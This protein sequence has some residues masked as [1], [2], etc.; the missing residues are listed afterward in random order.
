MVEKRQD[1]TVLTERST[2]PLGVIR[3]EQQDINCSSGENAYTFTQMFPTAPPNPGPFRGA[4][5]APGLPISKALLQ[6]MIVVT[7]HSQSA[8]D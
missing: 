1:Q 3:Q 4:P 6:R 8:K 5:F 7:R 2:R